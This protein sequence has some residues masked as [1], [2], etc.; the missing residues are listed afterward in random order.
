MIRP[1][2]TEQQQDEV[3]NL[4]LLAQMQMSQINDESS[5]EEITYLLSFG[6]NNVAQLVA[7]IL[8]IDPGD[9]IALEL[10]QSAFD[11]YIDKARQMEREADYRQAIALTRNANEVIPGTGTVRRLQRRI[12]DTEPAACAGE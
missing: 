11:I 12:C 6:P 2:L 5:I 3:Y 7:T 1:A 4:V 9:E 8:D 10:R